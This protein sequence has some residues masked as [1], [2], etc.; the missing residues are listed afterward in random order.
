MPLQRAT[1]PPLAPMPGIRPRAPLQAPLAP[2]GGLWWPLVAI[3]AWFALERC[4]A[5]PGGIAEQQALGIV[6]SGRQVADVRRAAPGPRIFRQD[7]IPEISCAAMDFG[8]FLWGIYD[9][10]GGS[11]PTP[12]SVPRAGGAGQHVFRQDSIPEIPCSTMDFSDFLWAIDARCGL[13]RPPARGTAMGLDQHRSVSYPV[14][15][16]Y[17]DTSYLKP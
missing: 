6:R 10:R 15:D 2:S 16:V 4:L 17:C 3:G 1:A 7:S 9:L 13:R 14:P 5:A 12:C 8:D 11:G